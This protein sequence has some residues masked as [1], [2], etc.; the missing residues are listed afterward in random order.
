M[1]SIIELACTTYWHARRHVHLAGRMLRWTLRP[2][3]LTRCIGCG[4]PA[5]WYYMP[6]DACVLA[7]KKGSDSIS[8]Q[9]GSVRLG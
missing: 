8:V 5:A 4:N 6:A 3:A 9:V 1:P 7:W 2:G